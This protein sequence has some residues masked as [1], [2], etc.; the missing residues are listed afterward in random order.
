MSGDPKAF[1]ARA[2]A[3]LFT[4]GGGPGFAALALPTVNNFG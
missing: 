1:V 3:Q 4:A 2:A